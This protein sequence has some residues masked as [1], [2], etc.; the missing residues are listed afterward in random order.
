M[1]PPFRQD[2]KDVIKR[3]ITRLSDIGFFKE[4]FHPD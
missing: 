2:N 1:T 3:E 4:V